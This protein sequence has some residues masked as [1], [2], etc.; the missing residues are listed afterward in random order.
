MKFMIIENQGGDLDL[1]IFFL[2]QCYPDCEIVPEKGRII[3][4]WSEAEALIGAKA[5]NDAEQIIFLDLALDTDAP[6]E[7]SAGLRHVTNIFAHCPKATWIA[8]TTFS[9]ILAGNDAKTRFHGILPKQQLE[10]RGPDEEKKWLIRSVI[11][12]AV[13]KRQGSLTTKPIEHEDSAGMRSFFAIYPKY[14]L[15]WL[16][17]T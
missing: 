3:T 9:D 15:D 6:Y 5:A 8:Y 11:E 12:D 17:A 10:S 4:K 14:V 2:S 7:A 1:L 13:R 16:T